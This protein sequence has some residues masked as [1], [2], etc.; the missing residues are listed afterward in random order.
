M[1]RPEREKGVNTPLFENEDQTLF[2]VLIGLRDEAL[3]LPNAAMAEVVGMDQVRTGDES[4]PGKI[5]NIVWRGFTLPVIDFD[6]M[7]GQLDGL[8]MRRPRIVVLH[9]LNSHLHG[10]AYAVLC[11]GQP[12]LI[13]VN[14]S[15]LRP[16]G[17]RPHDKPEYVL[18]RASVSVREVVIP[19]LEYIEALLAAPSAI[20]A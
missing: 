7:V 16:I 11:E 12:H 9:A 17:P 5:G 10:R 20:S 18:S 4:I 15:S 13:P 6:R 1:D 8:P 14:S 2:A 19:N 3:L